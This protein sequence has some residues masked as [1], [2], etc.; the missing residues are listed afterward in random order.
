M[1]KILTIAALVSATAFCLSGCKD[2]KKIEKNRVNTV[3]DYNDGDDEIIEE[4]ADIEI[5]PQQNSTISTQTLNQ[6]PV[7][8]TGQKINQNPVRPSSNQ[9]LNQNPIVTPVT[10]YNQDPNRI[11][12][13][14][15]R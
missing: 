15:L 5:V 2:Q 4:E 13:S 6:R 8:Q 3:N 11:P 14:N 7:Q 1:K 12:N 9:K 10:P